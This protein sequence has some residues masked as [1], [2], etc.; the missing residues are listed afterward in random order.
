MV[1]LLG[2]LDGGAGPAQQTT[3]CPSGCPFSSIQQ[4]INGATAGGTITIG[5]GEYSENIII[6][7]S[8]KLIG[9]GQDQV[10]ITGG[11]FIGG[12]NIR[13]A[14][15][16]FTLTKGTGI[17][18]IGVLELKMSNLTVLGHLGDGISLRDFTQ[19]KL[20]NV[21]VAKNGMSGIVLSE[22]AQAHLEAVVAQENALDGVACF[23]ESIPTIDTNSKLITN[24]A[25]GLFVAG[26]C[27]AFVENVASFGNGN[28]QAA[29]LAFGYPRFCGI[30][31]VENAQ[32]EVAQ[33]TLSGNKEAGLCIGGP[34][35]VNIDPAV[36]TKVHVRSSTISENEGHG[37]IAGNATKTQDQT[38]AVLE[39]N[40][41]LNNKGCGIF[42]DFE[43]VQIT[44]TE[45]TISG[46]AGGEVCEAK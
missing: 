9:V 19:A 28:A 5:A 46:N 10:K 31:V 12:V 27:N 4:A 11:I 22:S 15:E 14:L 35:S 26:S 23:G 25:N 32:A 30:T 24:G 29:L 8:I 1:I 2:V 44:L 38:T 40:A 45:N 41:I 39:N 6:L 20:T 18:A 7:K 33:A 13:I 21:I 3:V 37:V 17:I 43:N 36:S 34:S 16:G 42:K